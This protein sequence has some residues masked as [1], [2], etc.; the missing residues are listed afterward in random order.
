MNNRKAGLRFEQEIIRALAEAFG[1]RH[2]GT[3]K[4]YQIASTRLHS[5]AMDDRGVDVWCSM[6]PLS[7][8][9]IQLYRQTRRRTKKGSGTATVSVRKLL[10]LA[11]LPRP[12]MIVGDYGWRGRRKV[13]L[14]TWVLMLH[15]G[16][17]GTPRG[18]L[19]VPLK[20]G[21]YCVF[22]ETEMSIDVID[23]QTFIKHLKN[24]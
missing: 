11:D 20:E 2:P 21:T 16:C 7:R 23:F 18:S 10:R 24:E 13:R 5:K 1:L 19:T 3:S 6:P 22:H 17:S 14:G 12:V 9:A 8:Y 4:D 15:K